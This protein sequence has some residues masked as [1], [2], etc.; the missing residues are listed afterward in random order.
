[1]KVTFTLTDG[2]DDALDMKVEF[3]PPITPETKET[4]AVRA[5]LVVINAIKGESK[6]M[7]RIITP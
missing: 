4:A 2:T 7:N 6:E 1:M 5:A 3:D